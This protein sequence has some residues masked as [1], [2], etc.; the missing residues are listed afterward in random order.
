MGDVNEDLKMIR[1]TSGAEITI[2]GEVDFDGEAGIEIGH[3]YQDDAS[4][5]INKNQAIQIINHLHKVF[6]I[7]DEPT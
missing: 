6:E 7:T 4:F 3:P 1:E 5:Y 2:D